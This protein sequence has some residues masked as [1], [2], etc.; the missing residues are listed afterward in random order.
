MIKLTPIYTVRIVYKSGY[1]HDIEV[2]EFTIKNGSY[3]WTNAGHACK[4]LVLGIDEIAA[5]YQ[6]GVRR[7]L[8]W[9]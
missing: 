9:R 4:P 1:T 2:T 5:V 7:R 8:T 3:T 6:M